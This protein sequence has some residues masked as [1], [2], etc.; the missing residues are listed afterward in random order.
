MADPLA[1]QIVEEVRRRLECIRRTRNFFT[2][3]GRIVLH[4]RLRVD[5]DRLH[6]ACF[7]GAAKERENPGRNR[8]DVDLMVEVA[9]AVP[10]PESD[11]DDLG[12][13]VELV[14]ADVQKAVELPNA[15]TLGGIARDITPL[16]RARLAPIEGSK[17][18]YVS[19]TYLV[20]YHRLY[21]APD[22][23]V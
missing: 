12:R 22:E 6:L 14:V 4:G 1:Q 16:G 13:L 8:I 3:A 7:A 19:L 21:G 17:N 5:S 2:E 10:V 15:R 11:P 9:A 23:R 18:E 20:K